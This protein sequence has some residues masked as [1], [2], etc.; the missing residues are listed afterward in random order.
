MI[1]NDNINDNKYHNNYSIM[2]DKVYHLSSELKNKKVI[3]KI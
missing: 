3:K 1:N 2:L